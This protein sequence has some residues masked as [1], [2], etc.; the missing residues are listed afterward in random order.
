MSTLL[1]PQT[2]EYALRA[3]ACLAAHDR[4]EPLRASDL[5]T[6]AQIPLPYLQKVMRKLVVAGLVS[7]RKGHHGGFTLARP[8]TEI[9]FGDVLRATDFDIEADTHCAFG[10]GQCHPEAPCPLHPSYVR[11]KTTFLA[12]AE[13]PSLAAVDVSTLARLGR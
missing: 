12:W 13:S 4:A 9:T 3:M 6:D 8:A 2:A 1:I 10:F 5:A 7:G 11:L